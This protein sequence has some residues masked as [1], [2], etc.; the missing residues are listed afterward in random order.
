MTQPDDRTTP[1]GWTPD[2][3]ATVHLG[4][5]HAPD[6]PTTRLDVAGTTVRLGG[7]EATVRMAPDAATTRFVPAPAPGPEGQP[8]VHLSAAPPSARRPSAEPTT[9]LRAGGWTAY[10][11]EPTVHQGEATVRLR[12]PEPVDERTV[13]L[14][15]AAPAWEPTT[16]APTWGSTT[17]GPAW[18]PTTAAPTDWEPTATGPVGE[19]PRA[20]ATGPGTVFGGPTGRPV[21]QGGARTPGTPPPPTGGELRFGPGVPAAPPSAPAWPSL[22]PPPRRRPLWR[23]ATSVLSTLLTVVLVAVVGLYLWQQLRPLEIDGV[24]VAVPEPAGDRCDVTVDVVATVSTNGRAG[25]IR[26]QWLRSGSAPGAVLTERVGRGQRTVDLTL[27][28]SFSGVGRTTET[29]TVNITA[30]S[31]AQARTAVS[32]ACRR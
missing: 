32:Y 21:A 1:G 10:D 18:E 3:G 19:A 31:P 5:P 2:D 29:A 22:A 15:E 14:A 4:R 24:T 8:T 12:A 7:D 9:D 11:G 28:W 27:R 6:E 16:A 13:H 30:P 23:R 25:E 26:Y 17:A 20:T